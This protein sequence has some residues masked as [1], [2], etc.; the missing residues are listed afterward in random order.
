MTQASAATLGFLRQRRR[1]HRSSQ[2]R[3]DRFTALY[4]VGLYTAIAG[5]TGY[6]A[7][8]QGPAGGGPALWLAGGGLARIATVALLLALLA[9]LRFATW[10]GPVVFTAAE[11][12]WLLSSP[13]P[14]AELVRARLGRGLLAGAAAGAALGLA[15]FV[16]LEAELAVPAW[17]LLAAALGGLAAFGVLAA[18]LGWLVESSPGT[19]RAVLLASPLVLAAAAAAWL[20]GAVAAGADPWSGP[21]G[22]AAGPLVAAAGGRDPGWP[23]QAALLAAVTLAAVVAAWRTAARV[24]LEELERR[25]GTRAGLG[26][27]LFMA[28]ARGAALL[29][30]QAVRGL[31]GVRRLGLR[32]PRRRW[33]ALPWRDALSL[34]RAPGRV[35]WALVLCGSGALAV[36]LV[37]GRRLLA[38]GAV[39][40]AYLG[41]ARLVEPL[42]GEADQPDASRQLPWRW[43]DLV[44]LHTVTPILVLAGIGLAVAVA[45]ALAGLLP[46]A[47]LGMAAAACLPVAAALVWS[48]AIAGQRGRL[49]I[50]QFLTASAMGELAG[51]LYLLRWF[52]TGPLVALASLLVPVLVLQGAAGSPSPRAQAAA[53]PNAASLL[54]IALAVQGGWLRSRHA[55]D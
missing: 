11:V 17:P 30:H 20:G 45:L 34:L 9:T 22:W 12:Q 55:P 3:S 38:A 15:A 44:L 23:L 50:D 1:A 48:A 25:A 42:R 2:Q 47:A 7:L 14:R 33:L 24:T 18:A 52:A 36:A 53:V 39:V 35:G 54:A 13:L 37:P 10:Q 43:G 32:H 21:W 16:L 31:V 49:G 6:Q 27:S 28:D 19:A 40:A 41:A 4:T 51:P 46:A 8:R 5:W 26:A 29:R